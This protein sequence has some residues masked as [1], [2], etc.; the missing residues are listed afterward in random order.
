VVDAWT[1]LVAPAGTPRPIVDQLNAAINDGLKSQAAQ[2][3]L[4]KFSAIAKLGTPED[5]K[6]FL[7]E[8]TQKWASIVK[9]AD[10][11]ID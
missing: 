2:D 6:N 5:F 10:A 7:A 4:A 11:R 8:Q 9:L 1:G 3:N